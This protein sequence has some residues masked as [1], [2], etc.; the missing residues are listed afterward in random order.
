MMERWIVKHW[1]A[2]SMG[3][4]LMAVAV[5]IAY[6]QR[7]YIAIGSEWAIIPLMFL[8][9]WFIRTR[10]REARKRCRNTRA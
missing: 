8:V 9:E 3:C 10:R 1:I 6:A 5:R 2:L 7:G 4:S